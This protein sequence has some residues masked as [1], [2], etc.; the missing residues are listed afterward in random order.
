MPVFLLIA[1]GL[2]AASCA[3]GEDYSCPALDEYPPDIDYDSPDEYLKQGVQTEAGGRVKAAA[4]EAREIAEMYGGRGLDYFRAANEVLHDKLFSITSNPE[5]HERSAEEIFEAGYATGCTDFAVAGA[6]LLREMG[7]PAIVVD[8]VHEDFL[9]GDLDS[10]QY[11]GHYF[12]EVFD[13]AN[14][15]CTMDGGCWLLY[16]PMASMLYTEYDPLNPTLPDSSDPSKGH[17]AMAKGVDP[18]EME[19]D[20]LNPEEGICMD[21]FRDEF[22]ETGEVD[23]EE[24]DYPTTKL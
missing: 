24:V 14:N 22:Y 7:C 1:L 20:S 21:R 17:L 23:F 9:E 15:D 16:D 18:W 11:K 13:R 3:D 6:A 4:K 5:S 12:L 8:S 19:I 10:L 2:I